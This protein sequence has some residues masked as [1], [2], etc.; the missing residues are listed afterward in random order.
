[1][2]S[3]AVNF[4]PFLKNQKIYAYADGNIVEEMEVALEDVDNAVQVLSSK[5]N[6]NEINLIGNQDYLERFKTEMSTKFSNIATIN[7]ISR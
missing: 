6:A 3:I 4:Q 2:T 5:F 1:M 7:I